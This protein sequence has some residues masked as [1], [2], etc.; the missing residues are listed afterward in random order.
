WLDHADAQLSDT[1][2]CRR[3]PRCA[4]SCRGRK[5]RS[6]GEAG[7]GC[8]R[9]RR[10]L[11]RLPTRQCLRARTPCG[12]AHAESLAGNGRIKAGWEKTM[13]HRD[14]LEGKLVVLIGGGGFLGTHVAQE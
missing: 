10:F 1:G 14:P 11:T 5:P 4:E 13:A 6:E 9:P 8:A 7:T 12:M 3:C 2:A